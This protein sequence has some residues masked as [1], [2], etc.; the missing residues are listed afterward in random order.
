[1]GAHSDGAETV[2]RTDVEAET[3]AE[4]DNVDVLVHLSPRYVH[5]LDSSPPR[6]RQRRRTIEKGK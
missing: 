5:M 1:V 4:A 6:T 2:D 3:V